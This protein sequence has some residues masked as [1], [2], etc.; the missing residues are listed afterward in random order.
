[1]TFAIVQSS[2]DIPDVE[3]LKRAFRAVPTLTD[4]DAHILANDAFGILVKRKSAKHAQALIQSLRSEGIEAEMVADKLLP[5]M[6]ETKFVRKLECTPD[7][8]ILHDALGR[9]FPLPWEH[10]MLI[11]AGNVKLQKFNRISTER[12]VIRFDARGNPHRVTQTDY[13]SK[14]ESRFE[15]LLEIIL[16]RAILRYSVTVDKTMLFQ[17][18]GDQ[19]NPKLDQS[20]GQLI[21]QLTQFA[22][23]AGLNR[24]AYYLRENAE[25]VF[26]YP[27][28]N[29]FHEEIIW[30]LW[31]MKQAE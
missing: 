18:L 13:S 15:F 11:A 3:S 7:A 12:K 17:F 20:F 28:K 10:I 21:C 19:F 6:P 4:V 2:L 30:L 29:A 27:S 14:E 26:S 9:P 5:E 22:P 16:T 31:K 1:M 25:N 23:H 24:G 8:L